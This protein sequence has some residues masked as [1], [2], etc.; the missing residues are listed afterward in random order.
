MAVLVRSALQCELI[1]KGRRR[2]H[3]YT[4]LIAP[5][6]RDTQHSIGFTQPAGIE[7]II[8]H[9]KPEYEAET[10]SEQAEDQENDFP[11]GNSHTVLPRADGDAIG[12]KT[13]NNLTDTI[14][15][16]PDAWR[17]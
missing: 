12:N 10:G 9:Y 15:A 1:E 2:I 5:D 11:G 6:P 14:E 7:L 16:E 8:G 17:R 13:A 3:T 4:L